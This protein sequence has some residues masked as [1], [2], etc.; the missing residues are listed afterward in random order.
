MD[1]Q[2]NANSVPWGALGDSV[3]ADRIGPPAPSRS[4][5]WAHW[6]NVLITK[7][8]S[9]TLDGTAVHGPSETLDGLRVVRVPLTAGTHRFT[10]GLYGPFGLT[11]YGQG[12]DASYAYSGGQLFH[13]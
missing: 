12:C 6:A 13:Y 4:P 7:G 8:N 3:R 1:A 5:H 2:G 10:A 9:V 11:L